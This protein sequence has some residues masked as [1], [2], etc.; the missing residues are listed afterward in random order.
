MSKE[1]KEIIDAL[2]VYFNDDFGAFLE[3]EWY[4]FRERWKQLIAL[5]EKQ[6]QEKTKELKNVLTEILRHLR[7]G[8]PANVWTAM[9]LVKMLLEK[10]PEPAREFIEQLYRE[11]PNLKKEGLQNFDG[12]YVHWDKVVKALSWAWPDEKVGYIQSPL[13]LV[14]RLINERDESEA[15]NKRLLA[16]IKTLHAKGICSTMAIAEACGLSYKEVSGWYYE[17]EKEGG[18]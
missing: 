5:L 8:K 18:E 17:E 4:D 15:E 14:I 10:Q 3:G 9:G 16:F 2:Q 1:L 7:E 11:E 12:Y 13:E 6:P